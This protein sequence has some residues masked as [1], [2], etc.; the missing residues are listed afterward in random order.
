MCRSRAG[1][2]Q[3]IQFSDKHLS[4][5]LQKCKITKNGLKSLFFA[6]IFGLFDDFPW[7]LKAL[8]YF[9]K[10]AKYLGNC[11][12]FN[13]FEL[14]LCDTLTPFNFMEFRI[15]NM[16]IHHYDF[17]VVAN[18]LVVV[19]GNLGNL[20]NQRKHHIQKTTLVQQQFSRIRGVQKWRP[21]LY[22]YEWSNYENYNI[23][24]QEQ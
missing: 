11:Q 7:W 12:K 16:Q 20:C 24:G 17:V 19:Y 18:S 22:E 1:S 4:F 14:Q 21:F 9:G 2:R 8:Q 15:P 10:S 5:G 3:G 13:K 23:Q 6:N